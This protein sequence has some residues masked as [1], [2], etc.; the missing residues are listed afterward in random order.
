MRTSVVAVAAVSWM[1][2]SACYSANADYVTKVLLNMDLAQLLE[3]PVETA[4]GVTETLL[5]APAAMVV[6]SA[7]DIQRRGYIGLHEI[8]ADLPGFDAI[9]A[10]GSQHLV[11]YQRGYRTPFMQRT[12][13]M[14]NGVVDNHLWSHA[15]QISR[16][17]PLSAIKRVEVLYGP[18]S[19]VYG[20]NAFLGIINLV[21]YD[22]TDLPE[23]GHQGTLSLQLGSFNSRGAEAHA[24]GREG[25]W[26]YSISGKVFESDEAGLDDLAPWGFLTDN[27]LKDRTTW[28]AV[29]DLDH[30]KVRFGE[31]HDPTE[32][33]GIV[34]ETGWRDF[35]LGTILW[36][37]NEAYGQYYAADRVQPNIYWKH[38]AR[39]Y[40]LQHE[41][42]VSDAFQV[43]SQVSYHHNRLWGGWVEAIPDWDAGK[44]AYSYLSIS[45]WNSQN[46]SWLLKQDYD[47]QMSANWRITGGLKYERK[48]LTKAF[49]LCSYWSGT[50]CSTDSG[51]T[52]PYD[53]GSGVF[54]S[55]DNAAVIAPGTLQN[56]PEYNLAYTRDVGAY[57][58]ATWNKQPW[59]LLGGMR[60]DRNSMYGS[61]VNPRLSAIYYLTPKTTLKLLYGRAF[62]EPSPIQLWGGWI[63][64][65]GNPELLPEKAENLELIVMHQQQ[66]WLHD[67]SLFTAH[68]RDVIKEEAE[69][70]GSRDIYG[71]EYRGRFSYPNFINGAPDI[72]GYLYYTYTHSNSSITYEQ[73]TASWLEQDSELGDIAPHKIS[74][75]IDLPLS[76]R[77][78]ANLRSN[79]AADRILYS[80]N[81]LREQGR[82]AD[83]YTVLNL[84]LGYRNKPFDVQFKINNLLDSEYYQ[85]GL[86]QADSGD[87][88]NQR[89]LGFRNSLVPQEKRSLWLNV[90]WQF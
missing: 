13:L 49:D 15:A 61:S 11:A 53:M 20:P 90:R 47:Y 48:E 23:N 86:E 8:F 45:D 74:L 73:S 62:Q 18:T 66:N 24:S 22:D 12:L 71:L 70:A 33:W 31:Y 56:M 81:P 72:S 55:S 2:M 32:D 59:K 54:H 84:T 21:T 36:D 68:Y 43:K 4:S 29:L 79:F 88:F 25:K 77:W 19:A 65:A 63:G 83:A 69:N 46:H 58:Q 28:G 26:W 7:E 80:R 10:G 40:Y 76:R 5:E 1:A 44:E 50:V 89:S 39:Q 51:D 60:Y 64:R 78:Y 34:A 6:I 57:V 14:I 38:S 16:Q 37:T 67:V 52:G 17:Y 3:V 85:P 87:G 42:A 30:Q 82:K 9:Q 27:W 75:G 41:H 35:T